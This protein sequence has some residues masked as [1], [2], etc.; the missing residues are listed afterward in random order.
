M[1][2]NI[3]TSSASE[4]KSHV[5]L[6]QEVMKEVMKQDEHYGMIPGTKKNTLFQTGAQKLLATFRLGSEPEVMNTDET[7]Y[8]VSYRVK[9][10]IFNIHDG[11][12]VGYGMGECSSLEEKYAW[13][14]AVN[15]NE[16]NSDPENKRRVKHY[17]PYHKSAYSVNQIVVNYKDVSNTVLKMAIKRALVGA[18]LTVTAAGDIFTQDLEDMEPQT[19][20]S[21]VNS[22][23]D[24][25]NS[26][27]ANTVKSDAS[28]KEI[29]DAVSLLGHETFLKEKDGKTFL[30]VKG[31]C[32]NIKDQLKRMNFTNKKEQGAKYWDTFMDVTH[33][34][35]SSTIVNPAPQNQSSQSQQQTYAQLEKNVESLGLALETVNVDGKDY[36]SVIGIEIYENKDRLKALGFRW[37]NDDSKSWRLDMSLLMTEA[38]GTK[39]AVK[40][41][42]DLIAKAEMF[43]FSISTPELDAHGNNWIK[44]LPT[45]EHSDYQSLRKELGF[46]Y[47]S[48][49]DIYVLKLAA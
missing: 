40:V 27:T 42:K 44:A 1:L 15:E 41:S 36:A 39:E 19:R 3:Q 8:S 25:N 31:N 6:I 45:D 38:Q 34:I 12:T 2:S 7:D 33:L 23:Y 24:S 29:K 9:V 43:G 5:Q 13:K 20:D 18:V 49:K 10:R 46:T 30:F 28:L 17:Q 26:S 21:I 32:F 22:E 4:I 48:K 14:K 35:D 47:A 11:N 16:F 37:S